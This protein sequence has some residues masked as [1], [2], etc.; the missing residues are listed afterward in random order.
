MNNVN[1]DFIILKTIRFYQ[2]KQKIQNNKYN[3]PQKLT[4]GISQKTENYI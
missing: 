2:P 4:L 1:I 3:N